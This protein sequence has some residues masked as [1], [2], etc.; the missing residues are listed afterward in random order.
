[1]SLDGGLCRGLD[2]LE[3]RVRVLEGFGEH[4]DVG[5]IGIGLEVYASARSVQR[6]ASLD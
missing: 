5:A 3:Q 6:S 4:A 2:L 1:L